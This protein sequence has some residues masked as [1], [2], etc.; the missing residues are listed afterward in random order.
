MGTALLFA[1][2]PCFLSNCPAPLV[3]SV[4]HDGGLGE[5]DYAITIELNGKSAEFECWLA[6]EGYLCN[7]PLSWEPYADATSF[8]F[9]LKN[10]PGAEELWPII[11]DVQGSE[12]P[13]FTHQSSVFFYEYYL[14]DT[15]WEGEECTKSCF[16]ADE[17]WLTY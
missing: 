14:E 15:D 16:G 1:C 9:E 6:E 17:L 7:G 4:A 12:T 11:V 10:G 2:S 3:V 8:S 5:Q 13:G